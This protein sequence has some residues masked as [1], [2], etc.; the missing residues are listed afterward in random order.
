MNSTPSRADSK[1]SEQAAEVPTDQTSEAR[2]GETPTAS[3]GQTPTGSPSQT[4]ANRPALDGLKV[5]ELGTVIMAPYA[6]KIL[7]DLGA[8]VIKVEQPGGDIGRR[9]GL[10]GATGDSVLSMNLNASKHSIEIDASAEADRPVLEH[11][12]RWSDVI[13]TNLLPRR[14]RRYGLD[15]ENVHKLNP[16]TVLCTAQGFSSHTDLGD[17]PAYDDIIQAGSGVA[18]TYRLRD[19]RPSYSPY[20]VADKVCGMTMVQAVLAALFTARAS[21]E[22]TW[23][24]VPMIETMAA[25]TLVEHLGGQT[26]SPPR[27]DVGWSR[28]L[29]PEH[30]PHQALDGFMC[31]MPYTDRNWV[32]F[33]TLIARP[34]YLSHPDLLSNQ[35]RTQN[36]RVY[37]SVLAEYA[38]TRTCAQIKDECE[39]LSIPV[40]KVMRVEDIPS[41]DYLSESPMLSR[42]PHSKEGD[43]V[44][45]GSP[46]TFVNHPR[47]VVRETSGI[48]ADR[49]EILR[50]ID[51][52]GSC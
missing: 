11:L 28:V 21:G 24:D 18:D 47:P 30:R 34:D 43:F 2:P 10:G 17:R 52:P 44:H 3:P 1:A 6:G 41:D 5:L 15:W 8:T 40:Q 27:G 49:T 7:A 50:M 14:R 51:Y 37:E 12:I 35:A 9:I 23:V 26:Y 31:V 16:R 36:P 29:S 39:P 20:V 46:L 45:V 33:C 48:D 32:D 25:F 4:S 38:S 13:I 42:A 22:G 19:G